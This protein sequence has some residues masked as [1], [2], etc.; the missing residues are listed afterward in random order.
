[1]KSIVF[2]LVVLFFVV[3]P[4]SGQSLSDATG[5]INRLDVQT[6]GHLFEIKLTSNFDLTDYAFDKDEKEIT[7]YFDSALENNLA[8]LIVPKDLL[9]GNFIF[10]VNN[11]EFSP[12]VESNEKISF[13]T[14][15]FTGSGSNVVK[16]IGSEYLVGLNP[17]ISNDTLSLDY[18]PVFDD[19]F[20]WIVLGSAF[21]V[22][23]TCVVIIVRKIRK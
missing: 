11:Q 20:V 19:Y 9:S 3:A 16:I 12:R 1:M 7:L 21:T 17:I 15:N 22:I 10:Y 5:I 2:I 8:E 18:E 4:V 14:L 23:V 6:S 13:I